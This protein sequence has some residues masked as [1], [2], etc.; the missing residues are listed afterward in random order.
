MF[1]KNYPQIIELSFMNTCVS[2]YLFLA[3]NIFRFQSRSNFICWL[4]RE[5]RFSTEKRSSN[6]N[7]YW[8][9]WQEDTRKFDLKQNN[10]IDWSLLKRSIIPKLSFTLKCSMKPEVKANKERLPHRWKQKIRFYK[11]LHLHRM[12]Q[13]RRHFNVHK[14]NRKKTINIKFITQSISTVNST[15]FSCFDVVFLKFPY[16]YFIFTTFA[17]GNY[18]CV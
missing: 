7:F 1:F 4:K 8:H 2:A 18:W 3:K 15:K 9:W 14:V 17:T 5:K 6:E 10:F 11:R 12:S 13:R 16:K